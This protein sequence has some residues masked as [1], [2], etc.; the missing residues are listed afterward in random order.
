MSMSRHT[1]MHTC[2]DIRTYMRRCRGTHMR[3]CR[4]THVE[5]YTEAHMSRHTHMRRCR[6]THVETYTH[7]CTGVEAHMSRHTTICVCLTPAMRRC[8]GTHSSMPSISMRTSM[9]A[10]CVII[11]EQTRG[12]KNRC[13]AQLA[14]TRWCA[15]AKKKNA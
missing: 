4:G 1:Q 2:R 11:Y 7:I 5:T 10:V 8:R 6:G 12:S 15:A 9:T 3:R 13:A 14:A